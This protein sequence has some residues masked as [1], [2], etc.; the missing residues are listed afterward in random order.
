MYEGDWRHDKKHGYGVYAW[1]D[2]DKYEGEYRDGDFYLPYHK[3]KRAVK[4]KKDIPVIL[5]YSDDIKRLQSFQKKYGKNLFATIKLPKDA[6]GSGVPDLVTKAIENWPAGTAECKIVIY[7]H[8]Y[9]PRKREQKTNTLGINVEHLNAMIKTAHTKGITN[10]GLSGAVCFGLISKKDL[11]NLQILENMVLKIVNADNT[12]IGTVNNDGNVITLGKD[13]DSKNRGVTMLNVPIKQ[14]YNEKD[15][16][17][18]AEFYKEY[19]GSDKFSVDFSKLKGA[20]Q[21]LLRQGKSTINFTK[22]SINI[23][24]SEAGNPIYPAKLSYLKS[25]TGLGI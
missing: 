14:I 22:S 9:K 3:I 20:C 17:I 23:S 6:F 2:G 16:K 1:L 18:T 21:Y 12:R 10:L 11:Q 7:T 15:G 24:K 4:P 8:G 13:G 19:T 25:E 5:I